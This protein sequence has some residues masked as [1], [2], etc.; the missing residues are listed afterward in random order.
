MGSVGTAL[1]ILNL[2]LCE[3]GP[4]HPHGIE[5]VLGTHSIGSSVEH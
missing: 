1:R 5:K 3:D 2:A 4:S